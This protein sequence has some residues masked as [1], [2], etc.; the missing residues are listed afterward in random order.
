MLEMLR[1]MFFG[2]RNEEGS[3]NRPATDTPAAEAGGVDSAEAPYLLLSRRFSDPPETVTPFREAYYCTKCDEYFV[4]G[5]HPRSSP[6]VQQCEVVRSDSAP[7]AVFCPKCKSD[8]A[9]Y[10]AI[11]HPAAPLPQ[12]ARVY[13]TLEYPFPPDL[14]SNTG[15]VA[16]GDL[17]VEK[18]VLL[19]SGEFPDGMDVP[20]FA[21]SSVSAIVLSKHG[22]TFLVSEQGGIYLHVIRVSTIVDETA[23]LTALLQKEVYRTASL[24]KM[25]LT[26]GV[27]TLKP[28][29]GQALLCLVLSND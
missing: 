2:R 12:P 20:D 18:I 7:A 17:I 15:S 4:L 25:F 23:W 24:E 21:Y 19:V 9:I 27:M 26:Y 29:L 22:G 5:W 28:P 14:V 16:F 8:Y 11:E 13:E 1:K 3:S 10:G 6:L